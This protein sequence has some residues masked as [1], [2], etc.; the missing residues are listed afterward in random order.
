MLPFHDQDTDFEILRDTDDR[1]IR[2][3]RCSNVKSIKV[4]MLEIVT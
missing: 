2:R 3:N 4:T 1:M